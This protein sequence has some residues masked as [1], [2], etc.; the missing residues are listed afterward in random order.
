[1]AGNFRCLKPY[2]TMHVPLGS[3]ADLSMWVIDACV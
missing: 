2:Q 1:M 3:D